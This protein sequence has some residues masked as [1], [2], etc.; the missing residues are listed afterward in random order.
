MTNEERFIDIFKTN[1]RR[2]GADKLLEYLT[3]P[4]CDF[5]TA[6]ASTRYHNAWEGGLCAHSLNVYDIR[7]EDVDKAFFVGPLG[8][9][10]LFL[11][12]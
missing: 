7:F 9:S 10:F 3:G 6:P 12:L 2:E 8:H 1:V 11:V 4:G 5:F